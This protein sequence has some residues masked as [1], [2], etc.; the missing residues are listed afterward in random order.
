MISIR[1]A[2]SIVSE[3]PERRDIKLCVTIKA[4]LMYPSAIYPSIILTTIELLHLQLPPITGPDVYLWLKVETPAP[5][6]VLP[7]SN[8][9]V[10]RII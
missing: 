7:G 6:E 2:S 8:H 1:L 9:K 5:A 3:K 4:Y 10:T